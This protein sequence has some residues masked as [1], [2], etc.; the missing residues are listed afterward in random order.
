MLTI[1]HT[2]WN[3]N[4]I[5]EIQT[6]EGWSLIHLISSE[7]A[8]TLLF[9]VIV[10]II[11]FLGVFSQVSRR[12]FYSFNALDAQRPVTNVYFFK[13]LL[14]AS[15]LIIIITIIIIIISWH[16]AVKVRSSD[17]FCL[18]KKL[19]EKF[20]EVAKVENKNCQLQ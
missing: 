2:L 9:I 12:H 20:P 4:I 18:M 17:G 1:T 5:L 6:E 19:L 11:I 7:I 15:Y 16:E 14:I 13:S 3:L 10:F 8:L